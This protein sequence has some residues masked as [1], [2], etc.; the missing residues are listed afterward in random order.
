[1]TDTTATQQATQRAIS[2][3]TKTLTRNHG[4]DP[5]WTARAIIYE[6]ATLGWRPTNATRPP[7]WQ[8]RPDKPPSPPTAEWRQARN[9]LKEPHT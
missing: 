6:L 4:A 5:E 1:M 9:A 8:L 7:A 2:A 3:I